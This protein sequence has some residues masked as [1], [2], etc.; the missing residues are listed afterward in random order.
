QT[1]LLHHDLAKLYFTLGE[2]DMSQDYYEKLLAQNDIARKAEVE[3]AITKAQE[4][5]NFIKTESEIKELKLEKALLQADKIRI[6]NLIISG[7]IAFALILLLG[8]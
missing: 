1:E 8:L 7:V 3:A 2:Y 6:R 5:L 4:N